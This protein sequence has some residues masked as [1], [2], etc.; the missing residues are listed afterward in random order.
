MTKPNKNKKEIIRVGG[1]LKEVITV[2]NEEGDILPKI[3]SPLMGN[4]M[5]AT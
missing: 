1:K 5:L 2:Q 3:I 4:C